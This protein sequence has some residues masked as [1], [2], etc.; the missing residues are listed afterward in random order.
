MDGMSFQILGKSA[1]LM[2]HFIFSAE[3]GFVLI[4]FYF[5]DQVIKII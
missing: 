2:V 1:Y 5:W 4:F 3:G